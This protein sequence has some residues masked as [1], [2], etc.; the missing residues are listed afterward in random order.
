MYY[1]KDHSADWWR[2]NGRAGYIASSVLSAGAALLLFQT[3]F[4]S[5]QRLVAKVELTIMCIFLAFG[6]VIGQM[7]MQRMCRNYLR[8]ALFA[9]Q[10]EIGADRGELAK[11][12]AVLFWVWTADIAVFMV[13][14]GLAFA[15]EVIYAACGLPAIGMLFIIMLIK[16][17]MATTHAKKMK[18]I[19]SEGKTDEKHDTRGR[20]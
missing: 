9:E 4:E 8:N 13:V 19:Y 17:S 6:T 10:S 11:Y 14:Y 5:F 2:K 18:Q 7:I 15:N 12:D 1:Y 16:A 3:Q 20:V